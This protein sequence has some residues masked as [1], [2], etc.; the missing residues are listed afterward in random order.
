MFT[1]FFEE[2]APSIYFFYFFF[3]VVLVKPDIWLYHSLILD[4]TARIITQ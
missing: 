1:P 4:D 3:T 2:I